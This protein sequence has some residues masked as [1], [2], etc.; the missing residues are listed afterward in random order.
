MDVNN[1]PMP[2]GTTIGFSGAAIAAGATTSFTVANYVIG[3]GQH[4][5]TGP[6][7]VKIDEYDVP[8]VCTG[9]GGFFNV[10]VTTPRGVVTTL[11]VRLN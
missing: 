7:D 1:N 2:A 8:V 4:F 11:S 3:I 5:G 9:T 6:S 10:V